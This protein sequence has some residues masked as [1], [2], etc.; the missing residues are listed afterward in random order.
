MN[1]WA[2]N[3]TVTCTHFCSLGTYADDST[4]KCVFMCPANPISYSYLPTRTCEY[5]CPN[6][7]FA[8]E[9]GRTCM[10]KSCL[11]SPYFYYKDYLNNQCVLSNFSF[12]FRMC[13]PLFWRNF[14]SK[15]C[16]YML[17]RILPRSW[18]DDLYSMPANLYN[19]Y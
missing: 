7:Y 16:E 3:Q 9:M 1:S 5:S 19:L 17:L 15:L 13:L 12:I 8:S 4:W 18:S 14:Q 2:D 10:Y 6:N 11:T